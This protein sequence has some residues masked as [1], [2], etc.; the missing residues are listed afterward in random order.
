MLQQ[1]L[2]LDVKNKQI[3]LRIDL[4]LPIKNGKIT[5]NTRIIRSLPTI[6]Y[7]TENQAKTIIISHCGRPQGTFDRNK[8]IA[9]MADE[10]QKHV[11]QEVKFCS[12]S[13]GEKPLKAAATLL[14]GE[15]LVLENLR[16]HKG[17]EDCD[18]EFTKELAKLGEIYINDTF[19]CSHR[20]HASIFGLPKIMKSAAGFSL[21]DE[22]ENMEKLLSNPKQPFTAIIGGSKISSKTALLSALVDKVDNLVI[23]GAM[24]NTFLAAKGYNMGKSLFETSYIENTKDILAKAK[25]LGKKIILPSDLVVAKNNKENVVC[26][27]VPIDKIA[28]DDMVLDIGP[29]STEYISFIIKNSNSLVW[30][31]PM[32]A[33]ENPLFNGSTQHLARVISS[34]T[35]YY[36]LL[37]VVGGGDTIS[38]IKLAGLGGQFSYISTGGGAFLEWLECRILPGIEALQNAY[39]KY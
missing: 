33:F 35:L 20:K 19:S 27:I 12:E 32:G 21:I 30:N 22:L 10:L 26:R 11:G 29:N 23:G 31:G 3:L 34:Q 38:A 8:S 7:L 4:N 5:D 6:Q 2:D 25:S 1:L 9:I 14:P 13:I 16:F 36:D 24:A 17:E 28:N 18:E 39:C 37:S 15:I